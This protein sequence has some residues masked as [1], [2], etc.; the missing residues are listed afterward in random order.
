MEEWNDGLVE[1]WGVNI[2][3]IDYFFSVFHYS[4][5][6]IFLYSTFYPLQFAPY[7]LYFQ[8]ATRNISWL[9][10][11]IPVFYSL[12]LFPV[13][14]LPIFSFTLSPCAIFLSPYPFTLHFAF[15]IFQFSFIL[16]SPSPRLPISPSLC[17]PISFSPTPYPFPFSIPSFSIRS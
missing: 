7:S 4:N 14:C 2:F 10:A 16:F 3:W 8:L 15:Y 1:Y 12:F 5:I 6:P 9:C 13:L 17:L 11:F